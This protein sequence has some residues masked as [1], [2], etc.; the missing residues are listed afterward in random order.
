MAYLSGGRQDAESIPM[1]IKPLF[2]MR[3]F[4]QELRD[5]AAA[6]FRGLR[7]MYLVLAVLQV[8]GEN[9]C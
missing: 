2:D 8:I 5:L 7:Q 4:L 9:V 3:G 6:F 1:Q